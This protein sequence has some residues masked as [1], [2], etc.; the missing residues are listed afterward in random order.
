MQEHDLVAAESGI[1][2]FILLCFLIGNDFLTIRL[3]QAGMRTTY[4][5]SPAS[6]RAVGI[7]STTRRLTDRLTRDSRHD[8]CMQTQELFDT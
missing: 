4:F 5:R 2:D 8:R 1:D 7:S 6:L 3:T